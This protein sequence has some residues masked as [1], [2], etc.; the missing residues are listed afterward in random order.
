MINVSLSADDGITWLYTCNMVKII[1]NVV[2]IVLV[3]F[4]F[5][6]LIIIDNIW[7]PVVFL[8]SFALLNQR[9]CS[10]DNVFF[11]P[12]RLVAHFLRPLYLRF[13]R[14]VYLFQNV[15]CVLNI[16]LLMV[17]F[18][19]FQLPQVILLRQNQRP[20]FLIVHQRPNVHTTVE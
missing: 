6:S 7:F 5:Q 12:L 8:P 15:L 2:V 20:Q 18:V 9:P 4:I 19:Y 1:K 14:M 13:H 10:F 3:I 17:S 11:G 16:G